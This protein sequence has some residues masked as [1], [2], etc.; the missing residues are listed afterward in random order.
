MPRG[1]VTNLEIQKWI[2]RRHGF[3]AETGWIESCKS[4]W[5]LNRG[6]GPADQACPPDKKPILRQAFR[7]FGMLGE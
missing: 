2:L 7:A 5:G 3:V 6:E 1:L 4:E